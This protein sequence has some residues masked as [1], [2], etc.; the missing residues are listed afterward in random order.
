MQ[1]GFSGEVDGGYASTASHPSGRS[2]PHCRPRSVGRAW[3]GG[4][5]GAVVGL[6]RTAVPVR[7]AMRGEAGPPLAGF[8]TG[9]GVAS[10]AAW[11]RPGCCI[12]PSI[13]GGFA[14][15]VGR[16]TRTR[17]ATERCGGRL[18][19]ASKAARVRG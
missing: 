12:G 17:V 8:C 19:S 1:V 14:A 5:R 7:W 2:A 13:T 16:P 3:G 18:P 10:T 9:T 15:G 6:P 4:A 11:L